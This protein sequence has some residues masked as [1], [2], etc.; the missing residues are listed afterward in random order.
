MYNCVHMIN[1]KYQNL[2]TDDAEIKKVVTEI[3]NTGY[4][5][6]DSF[7]DDASSEAFHTVASDRNNG[8]KKG[9]ELKGTALYTLAHSDEFLLLSQRLY[10]ARCEITGEPKVQL[11]KEKQ[12][13]GLP[14]KDA[15]HNGP[16]EET[17]YHFD[18]AHINYLLPLILPADQ[19]D[20]S[21]NLVAFPNMRLK[22]PSLVSKVI[23][24]MLRHSAMFR[25]WYG[26]T[27]VVYRTDTM[28]I[29]FADITFHGVNPISNGERMVVTINSHW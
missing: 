11:L 15:T 27:E 26:E 16:N 10:D 6:L 17:A 25:R 18:G 22:Y 3:L 14:Y 20:G 21:G 4:V 13:V 28:F 29:I 9:E 7:L 19:S 1:Q 2:L 5:A 8:W 23:A 24:R 12:V